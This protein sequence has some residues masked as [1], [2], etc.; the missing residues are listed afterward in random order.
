MLERVLRTVLAGIALTTVFQGCATDVIGPSGVSQT[1]TSDQEIRDRVHDLPVYG[2]DLLRIIFG[3]SYNAHLADVIAYFPFG[4][5]PKEAVLITNGHAVRVLDR[6]AVLWAVVIAQPNGKYQ[7]PH[8]GARLT[9][10]GTTRPTLAI[11]IEQLVATVLSGTSGDK[12]PVDPKEEEISMRHIV[13]SNDTSLCI[14]W[15]R[16]PLQKDTINRLSIRAPIE[17][18]DEVTKVEIIN[19]LPAIKVKRPADGTCAKD[20]P[21]GSDK[22]VARC[23][24]LS[25][26]Q[27]EPQTCE[28]APDRA[29]KAKKDACE[30]SERARK[31]LER[32]QKEGFPT[33]S[34]VLNFANSRHPIY[35]ASV[36]I[37]T[38]IKDISSG[39]YCGDLN[40]SISGCRPG[41]YAFGHVQL[42]PRDY[43]WHASPALMLSAVLGARVADPFLGEAVAG[44]RLGL[45][46]G[47]PIRSLARWG[48]IGGVGYVFKTFENSKT[49]M[50]MTTTTTTTTTTMTTPTTT[51][52]DET[53][54]ESVT[55][56]NSQQAAGGNWRWF[57]GLDF[58]F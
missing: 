30:R 7:C 12:V 13:A 51:M 35:G 53:K 16:F 43:E 42:L 57:A 19:D 34:T 32:G 6:E 29:E 52:T 44:L 15:Q 22:K 10:F 23:E 21:A 8:V 17:P 36:A 31:E 20:V 3:P 38:D 4:K 54:A 24:V 9:A 41:I 14:G 50:T 46:E 40:G 45:G 49:T 55:T 28:D 26:E 1:L 5:D 58:A 11:S 25:V 47:S 27:E 56:N 18:D 37:G 2:S 39:R 48:V 33:R